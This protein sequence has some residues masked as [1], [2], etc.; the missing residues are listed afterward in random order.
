[1]AGGGTVL[2]DPGLEELREMGFD[3][4]IEYRQGVCEQLKKGIL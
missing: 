3:G 1:M 2:I 4:G